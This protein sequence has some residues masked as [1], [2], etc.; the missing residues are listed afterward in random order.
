MSDYL[1][2]FK[3]KPIKIYV[4]DELVELYKKV[5]GQSDNPNEIIMSTLVHPASEILKEDKQ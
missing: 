2:I 1:E 5:W 4:P 3:S